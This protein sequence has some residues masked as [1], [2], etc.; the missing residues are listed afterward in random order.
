[1]GIGIGI[2]IVARI[3][4]QRAYPVFIVDSRRG[5][6]IGFIVRSLKHGLGVAEKH[7]RLG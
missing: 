1:M 6:Q 5:L 2:E 4:M 7:A 3:K